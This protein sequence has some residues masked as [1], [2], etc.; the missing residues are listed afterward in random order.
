MIL[1]DCRQSARISEVLGMSSKWAYHILSEELGKKKLSVR[2]VPWLLMQDQKCIRVKMSEECF[3][4]FQRNQQD[5][6]HHLWPQIEHESTTIPQRQR[7]VKQWKHVD[8]PPPKKANANTFGQVMR[9]V[10]WD[11]NGILL[12]HYKLPTSQT[13]MGQYYANIMDQLQQKDQL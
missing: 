12:I 8:S 4:L 2:W 7:T 10:F 3:A 1:E 11:A 9:S 5:F 13:I 6:L